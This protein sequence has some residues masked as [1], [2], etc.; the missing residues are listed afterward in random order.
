MSIV[1]THKRGAIMFEDLV[2]Y[3][4]GCDNPLINTSKQNLAQQTIDR[5]KKEIDYQ[6]VLEACCKRIIEE[7]NPHPSQCNL[8][9]FYDKHNRVEKIQVKIDEDIVGVIICGSFIESYDPM[10]LCY[11]NPYEV[12]LIG[13]K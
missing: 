10:K 12:D 7:Y 8:Y 1:N 6:P 11:T 13:D 4:R 9:Y 3:V 2:S 5:I